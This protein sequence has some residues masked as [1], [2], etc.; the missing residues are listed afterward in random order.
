MIA[1]RQATLSFAY[2]DAD[3]SET[4]LER[5]FRERATRKNWRAEWIWDR[6]AADEKNIYNY[7]RKEFTLSGPARQANVLVTADS[8]YQLFVN[9]R[10]VGRGP[11]RSE[12]RFQYYDTYDLAPFLK[13][14][15]NVIAAVVHFFGVGNEIYLLGRPGFLFEG[16]I[17]VEGQRP[18]LIKSDAS[19]QVQRSQAWDPKAPRENGSNGF[20]EICDLR[21]EPAGWID[22]EFKATGWNPPFIIGKPPQKPWVNLLPRDIPPMFEREISPRMVYRIG[23]VERK[24]PKNPLLVPEQIQVEEVRQVK[25]VSVTNTKYLAG[26]NGKLT[27]VTTS[28][29]GKDAVVLLDFGKEIAGFPF[30]ELEGV[31]GATV[32]VSFSEWL[33]NGQIVTVRAPIRV[34]KIEGP[35]IYTADRIILRDGPQR[36]QRFLFTGV[37]PLSEQSFLRVA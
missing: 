25:T 20:I 12:P 21:K 37:S 4:P 23:E 17:N 10:F 28:V 3:R 27:T 13:K 19:W 9:G 18:L 1:S 32:D 22:P 35:P 34:G 11:I 31:A 5:S 26:G 24:V 2:Q 29:P 36:W 6:D 16:E 8:R 33:H 14:G 15:R 30:I 7:F